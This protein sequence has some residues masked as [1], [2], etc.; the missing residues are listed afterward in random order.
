MEFFPIG[1]KLSLF[2]DAIFDV[3]CSNH[4]FGLE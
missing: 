3:S 1:S 2:S 4:D